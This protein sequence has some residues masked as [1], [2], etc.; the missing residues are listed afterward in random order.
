[1]TMVIIG[2]FG[3]VP[4]AAHQVAMSIASTTWNV[5][6]GIAAAAAVRCGLAVGRRDPQG[7][8]R[9]SGLSVTLGGGI[10]GIFG[11]V[12][13]AI[14]SQLARCFTSDPEVVALATRLLPIAGLFQVFDG[15]QTVSAGVLRGLLDTSALLF[16]ALVGYW[17]IGTPTSV[18]L[19]CVRGLGPEGVWW[20]M[21]AGL[22]S[23]SAILAFRVVRCMRK[24]G[25]I[26]APIT[27]L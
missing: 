6:L 21:I 10:M 5:S 26:C 15:V 1:V 13:L 3:V 22:F 7:V 4:V 14:P 25:E 9:A 11:I 16:A 2:R 23:A 18:W 17:L 27:K 8:Q 20:G 19:G 24:A 12:M